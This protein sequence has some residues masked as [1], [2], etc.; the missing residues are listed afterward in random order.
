MNKKYIILAV[1]VAAAIVGTF[2]KVDVAGV[3]SNVTAIEKQLAP[4]VDE[5]KDAV[6]GVPAQ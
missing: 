4:L 6:V 5:P 1:A 2:F 3:L